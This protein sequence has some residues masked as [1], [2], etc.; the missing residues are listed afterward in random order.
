MKSSDQHPHLTD[1]IW[2]QNPIL[3]YGLMAAF[4]V[5]YTDNF[6]HSLILCYFFDVISLSVSLLFFRIRSKLP[7][8]IC[9]LSYSLLAAL[10]YIPAVI[11][12]EYLFPNYSLD[13]YLPLCTLGF[14]F[15]N[16]ERIQSDDESE[17]FL[18]FWLWT[19]FGCLGF[20]VVALLMGMI[21]EALA[22]GRILNIKLAD[23]IS[24]PSVSSPA[25]GMILLGTLSAILQK[26]VQTKENKEALSDATPD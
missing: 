15:I 1:R 24:I 5:G 13:I 19:L 14:M 6:M 23:F 16:Q 9:I 7:Y 17:G 22:Y 4:V 10:V 18:H 11:A 8:T 21:R 2:K 3:A 26:T 12:A 20:D 25:F